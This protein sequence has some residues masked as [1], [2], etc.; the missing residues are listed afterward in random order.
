MKNLFLNIFF[1]SSTV[2]FATSASEAPR[3][4][5]TI[6]FSSRTMRELVEYARNNNLEALTPRS[7]QSYS[8]RFRTLTTQSLNDLRDQLRAQLGITPEMMAQNQQ[9]PAISVIFIVPAAAAVPHSGHVDGHGPNCI[10]DL[11]DQFMPRQGAESDADHENM[12]TQEATHNEEPTADEL[13]RR[14][15]DMNFNKKQ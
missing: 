2:S 4:V 9:Q 11:L 6:D 10:C 5:P 15:K 14:M 12:T 7:H 3:P 1:L 8:N 13:N